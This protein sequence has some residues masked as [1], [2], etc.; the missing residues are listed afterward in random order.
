M[1]TK[2]KMMFNNQLRFHAVYV[3]SVLIPN[4]YVHQE[5]R[6]FISW[7]KLSIIFFLLSIIYIAW[8]E[9]VHY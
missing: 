3:I 1:F 8:S 7:A 9:I 4:D 5:E 2:I 6:N